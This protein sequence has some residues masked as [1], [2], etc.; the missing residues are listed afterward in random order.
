M[1]GLFD[2]L[3]VFACPQN[4]VANDAHTS[5]PLAPRSAGG[6]GGGQAA[7]DAL[8]N[9]VK[10]VA[11]LADHKP[12]DR[13]LTQGLKVGVGEERMLGERCHSAGSS[14]PQPGKEGSH[15]KREAAVAEGSARLGPCPVHRATNARARRLLA[16]AIRWC[17]GLVVRCGRL[18]ALIGG[19]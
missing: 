18:A 5:C 6:G 9:D 14:A 3:L 16:S 4:G 2:Q 7:K 17:R 19:S 8:G 13:S 12:G 15:R 11:W 10:T 1:R